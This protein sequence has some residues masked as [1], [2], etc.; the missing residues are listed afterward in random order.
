MD[1]RPRLQA[2]SRPCKPGH[3]RAERQLRHARYIL[4]RKPLDI[5]QDHYFAKLGRYFL[6]QAFQ[7]LTVDALYQKRLRIVASDR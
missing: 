3:Y 4:V 7:Q 6:E 1:R 5:T 2:F